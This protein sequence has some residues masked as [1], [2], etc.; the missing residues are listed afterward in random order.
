MYRHAHQIEFVGPD[1]M[2]DGSPTLVTMIILQHIHK[3]IPHTIPFTKKQTRS[4][5][6]PGTEFII[7]IL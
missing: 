6:T 5:Q 2:M 7:I 4:K 1:T 3:H